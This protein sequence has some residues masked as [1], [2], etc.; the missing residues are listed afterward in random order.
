[1]SDHSS[2]DPESY[3]PGNQLDMNW[4]TEEQQV[5]EFIDGVAIGEIA[6]P[7]IPIPVVPSAPIPVTT[8]M[9]GIVRCSA[10]LRQSNVANPNYQPADAFDTD[11]EGY[12]DYEGE[13]VSPL[14]PPTVVT[15]ALPRL[16]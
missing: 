5:E 3:P 9:R 4:D 8:S 13:G 16:P 1:M 2:I 11:S 7:G 10:R 12:V 14:P 6:S 15:A